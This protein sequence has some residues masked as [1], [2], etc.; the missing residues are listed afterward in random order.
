MGANAHLTLPFACRL[1]LAVVATALPPRPPCRWS[2]ARFRG[3]YPLGE[4][5]WDFIA[6]TA[7][8]VSGGAASATLYR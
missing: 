5:S 7:Q 8:A 4:G 6:L 2:P 3:P 1:E